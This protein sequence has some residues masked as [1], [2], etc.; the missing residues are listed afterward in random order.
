MIARLPEVLS[1][2]F[3][4]QWHEVASDDQI[5]RVISMVQ[6]KIDLMS[7]E[8]TITTS[9]FPPQLKIR[10]LRGRSGKE[11]SSESY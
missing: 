11:E 7:M 1:H 9:K 8:G 3:L 5:R 2:F 4:K 10:G 6:E